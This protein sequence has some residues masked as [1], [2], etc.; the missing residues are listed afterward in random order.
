MTTPAFNTS[1]RIDTYE[2]GN[3]ECI[4]L[5]AHGGNS[6]RPSAHY[7]LVDTS[8][9]TPIR[10]EWPHTPAGLRA[11]RKAFAAATVSL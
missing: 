5:I 4:S 1:T 8:A 7:L 11:A 10:G 9:A 2:L 3:D 6:R